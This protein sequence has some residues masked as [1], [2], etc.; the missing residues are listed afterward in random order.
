MS[1]VVTPLGLGRS[2]IPTRNH[3]RPTETVAIEDRA[4]IQQLIDELLTCSL[5]LADDWHAIGDEQ[6]DWVL[7]ALDQNDLIDR[8]VERELLTDY[9]GSRI[10][11]G[12]VYGLVLGNYR[13]LDRVGAGG[14][15]IVFKA[16]HTLLRRIVALK[17]LPLSRDQDSRMLL[18]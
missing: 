6:R 9:Q 14:M 16:E 1:H 11:A 7:A 8:L 4:L 10:K 15:G 3:A 5:I 12:T 13:V 18:R 17:V 2:A